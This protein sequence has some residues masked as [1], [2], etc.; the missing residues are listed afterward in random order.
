M[1]R[2][3]QKKLS[4]KF[5]VFFGCLSLRTRSDEHNNV[6]IWHFECVEKR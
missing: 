6:Q 1:I 2:N 4:I 5:Y 3:C